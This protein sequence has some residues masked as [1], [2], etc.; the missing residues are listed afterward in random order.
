MLCEASVGSLDGNK[1][2]EANA[3]VQVAVG[4]EHENDID[5]SFSSKSKD[6]I[7]QGLAPSKTKKSMPFPP[8]FNQPINMQAQLLLDLIS[9]L[10]SAGDFLVLLR[11]NS[12]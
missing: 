8:P 5:I 1:S 9:T 11:K 2:V 10:F 6:V 12:L 3:N 4:E 7:G